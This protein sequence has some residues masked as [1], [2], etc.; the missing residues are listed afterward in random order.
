MP[1]PK[2]VRPFSVEIEEPMPHAIW[3]GTISFGLVTIPVDLLAAEQARELAFHLL[4]DRDMAPIRNKRVNE[5]TGEDVPWEHVTRGMEVEEG[6]WVVVTD[7]D[8]R[9][10]DVEATQTID[11]LAAVCA[12]EIDPKYFDK[13]YYLQPE[14]AGRKA[15]VLLR[16]AL[17]KARRVA[18]AKVVVRTRQRLAALVPDGDVILLEMLRYPYELRDMADLDLP[19]AD[20][21]E[22]GVTPAEVALAA[23][24]VDTIS[25][26]FDP[27]APE[28]RDTY[29]DELLAL[30]QRK[31]K[32]GEVI[33]PAAPAAVEEGGTVVDI[34]ALLKRSLEEAKKA[35]A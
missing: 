19:G 26:P 10:A 14:K 6:S 32:G 5:Q 29:H 15:Y 9:A 28:Y 7:D 2:A 4:D 20:A 33:V 8:M 12:E 34:A 30:I 22:T 25:K 27:A 35:R 3:K 21:A 16:E 24:L 23:Q 31:A 1:S 17:K 13:P 11:V 18:L